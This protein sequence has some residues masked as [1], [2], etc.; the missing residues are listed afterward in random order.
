MNPSINSMFLFSRYII[1]YYLIKIKTES[2][3]QI[4]PI[5]KYKNILKCKL[6]M[7]KKLIYMKI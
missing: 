1:K 2:S 5:Q 4:S 7:F 6:K 3:F